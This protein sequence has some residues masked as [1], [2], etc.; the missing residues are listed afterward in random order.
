MIPG[1]ALRRVVAIIVFMTLGMSHSGFARV[2]DPERGKRLH[3]MCLPCHG[4]EVYLPP[5]RKVATPVA[6]RK[7]VERWNRSYN[8][9]LTGDELDD[10][11]AWLDREFYRFGR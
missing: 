3:E 4:T 6:L 11:V 9:K 10:L 5:R 7:E 8:P 2:P 1:D